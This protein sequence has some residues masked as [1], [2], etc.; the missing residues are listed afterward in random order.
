MFSISGCIPNW[1]NKIAAHSLK[2]YLFSCHVFEP[3]I[4]HWRLN[5][6]VQNPNSYE[7]YIETTLITFAARK[8]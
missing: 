8:C 1:N 3:Q 6:A 4:D 7:E 5:G 2:G